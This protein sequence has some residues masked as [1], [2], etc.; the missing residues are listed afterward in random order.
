MLDLL[1]R[2][3]Q[4]WVAKFLLVLL[5]ASFGVWGISGSLFSGIGTS[6]ITAGD[7]EVTPNEYRLA[8]DRQM[9]AVGRQLGTQLTTE[10]ARAF[11]IQNQVTSQLVAG[12]VLDEQ[13]REMNL[14]LSKDRLASL[15]AT[16]PSFHDFNGRF[17]RGNFQRVLRSV[18]MSE[19]DY[20]KSRSQVAVRTQIIEAASDGLKAPDTLL[21]ALAQHQSETRDVDFL[22]ITPDVL[23]PIA[24]ADDA[25]LQSYFEAN[26]AS[27]A[28]PEYRKITYVKLQSEDIADPSSITDEAVRADY[29]A[30][31]AKYRID[32]ARTVDQLVFADRAAADAAAS[33]L[34]SGTSFDE[35]AAEQ[36][37][38]AADIRIGEFTQ[39]TAPDKAIGDAAFAINEAGG[40][41]PVI[42]GAFGP[43][44]IRVSAVKP[45]SVQGFEDVE[46]ELR[47]ELAL[48]AA[49]EQLLNVH[50]GYE[51][52]RAGGMTMEEAAASQKL[53]TVTVDAVDRKAQA[54]DGT[55]LKDL[56]E[57]QALLSEAFESD[58]GVETPP[59]NM[60]SEGFLWFEVVD[61]IEA[62]DRTLDEVR[63]QVAADWLR[64][65]TARALDAKADDLKTRVANGE[66]LETVA[67]ELGIA[68]ESKQRLKRGDSDAV[69]GESAVAA[70]FGGGNG[71]SGV[72]ADA[73]GDNRILFKVKAV[74]NAESVTA[75]SVPEEQRTQISQRIGDDLLDQ[76]VAELRATYRISV[77]QTLMDNSLAF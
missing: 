51:D 21:A 46:A 29:D 44:I 48:I 2:A 52:A 53:K 30:H 27:Y 11:G 13:S 73:Q 34:A 64:Q 19:E 42:D 16:D 5:V 74:D 69:L 8:Y 7:T 40:V 10:Q 76:L 63:D 22:L 55:V 31:L 57:S 6:V 56:P 37:K 71:H 65:E 20:L 24:P 72:V 58:I 47:K 14:G 36:G 4:G 38:S 61:I 45:E 66:T 59:I 35:L 33:R 60:G 23:G 67:A 15:V 77:N 32:G 49:N 9:A 17:D 68:V 41:S 39:A 12:A 3:A 75:D 28:A 62:R 43:V 1:R 25:A 54:P 70:A 18:G 50:D 26:K